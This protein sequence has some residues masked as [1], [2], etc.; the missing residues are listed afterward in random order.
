MIGPCIGSE[1]VPL[2]LVGWL[3]SSLMKVT[4]PRGHQGLHKGREEH[5]LGSQAAPAALVLMPSSK[6]K[7]R[8]GPRHCLGSEP[9]T[10]RA[11]APH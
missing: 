3:D 5:R 1:K 4:V 11:S 10:G 2:G 9:V 8:Q 7:E 6:D